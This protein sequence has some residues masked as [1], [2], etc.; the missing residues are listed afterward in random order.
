MVARKIMANCFTMLYG[1][2]NG[3]NQT[4]AKARMAGLTN[5]NT[6]LHWKLPVQIVWEWTKWSG[7]SRE[8][9]GRVEERDR[10][11]A[12]GRVSEGKCWGCEYTGKRL[13]Q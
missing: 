5:T 13:I 10:A 7:E 11:R 4:E 9:K 1:K 3:R 8:R 12:A 6:M 2:G